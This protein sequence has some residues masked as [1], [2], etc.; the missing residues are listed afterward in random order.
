M[1]KIEFKLLGYKMTQGEVEKS[2]DK[3]LSYVELP[4]SWVGKNV[5][6][7]LVDDLK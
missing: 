2:K 5:V 1:E 7:I 6:V 3:K 4:P